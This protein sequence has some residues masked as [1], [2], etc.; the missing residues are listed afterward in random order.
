MP[1]LTIAPVEPRT[2]PRL[3]VSEFG[4]V[5]KAEELVDIITRYP[6]VAFATDVQV[7]DGVIDAP[8]EE[9]AGVNGVGAGNVFKVV[10]LTILGSRTVVTPLLATIR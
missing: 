5:G 3:H 8:V 4:F 1:E 2:H 7:K 6:D 9:F 10:K